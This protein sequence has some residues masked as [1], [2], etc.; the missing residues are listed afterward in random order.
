MLIKLTAK[1]INGGFDIDC[2]FN[3]DLNVITGRNGSGKTTLL[4]LI[5]YLISGNI[6]RIPGE[7]TFDS[8]YLDTDQF[9]ISLNVKRSSS[10]VIAPTQ[11]S[12]RKRGDRV[13]ISLHQKVSNESIQFEAEYIE[14]QNESPRVRDVNLKIAS[15][16]TSI[17]FPT[18]RR[19]EGG[20]S[21]EVSKNRNNPYNYPG[22]IEIERSLD[23]LSSILSIKSH[24]F[25]C[26]IST[27]DIIHLVTTRYADTSQQTNSSHL[28]L[29]RS[30]MSEI[31]D[32]DSSHLK[33]QKQERLQLNNANK[34]IE[35]IRE[36]TTNFRQKQEEMLLPFNVLSTFIATV[37]Q[38]KGILLTEKISL[39]GNISKVPSELLSAGEKQILSFLVYNSFY[40]EVPIFI[41]EP[42]LSLHVD[43]QRML[44]SILLEQ[45]TGNQ[46]II[47]THSPF[48]Y[49]RYA[50]KEIILEKSRGE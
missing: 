45:N 16:G 22:A 12:R 10:S 6:E 29:V 31:D 27:S 42:E 8:V 24:R 4:K 13:E 40:S 49:S 39:G 44:F 5:W 38:E 17:F 26:S 25:V 23:Q 30:I 1:G 46:F 41:D 20:F 21:T 11:R 43:W 34:I 32:Q 2:Q 15:L 33:N 47:A 48:I 18:F 35:K 14:L 3:K 19:I 37:F 50:D 36:L 9:T 28:Q 7:M